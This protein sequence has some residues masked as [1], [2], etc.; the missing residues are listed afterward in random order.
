[1]VMST[2]YQNSRLAIWYALCND[3]DEYS[4]STENLKIIMSENV[5]KKK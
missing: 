5:H 2:F 3:N 4:G 1:M